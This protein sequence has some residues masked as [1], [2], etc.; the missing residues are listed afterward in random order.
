MLC[1]QTVTIAQMIKGH[2]LKPWMQRQNLLF[3][4]LK[5]LT[6]VPSQTKQQLLVM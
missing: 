2:S 3:M 6:F 1:K 5:R 4:I